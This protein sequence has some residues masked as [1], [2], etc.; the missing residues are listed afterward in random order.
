MTGG[1]VPDPFAGHPEWAP[2]PPRPIV[3]TPAA[4]AES[5]TSAHLALESN[6]P[7]SSIV[8]MAIKIPAG[9]LNIAA[10]AVARLLNIINAA[11]VIA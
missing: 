2:E 6:Q 3:P 10:G 1:A 5:R 11:Q 4:M 7:I 9:I 8:M